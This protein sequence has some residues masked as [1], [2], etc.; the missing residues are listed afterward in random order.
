MREDAAIETQATELLRTLIR[1]ACVNTGEAASGHEVRSVDA[2]E[3]FFAGSG[4]AC[5]RYTAAPGRTSLITRI[6][7]RDRAA[8]TLLLM[9]H[10]DVVPVNPAGWQRDPFAAELV[11]GIVWGRG[12]IDM[13]NLTATMAVATRR[14]ATTGFR[15]RGTLI[16]LA[17][18]DEEAGGTYGADHLVQR[19]ADAVRCD[20]VITESGGV[21]I[22]A[23]SGPV[24][25]V[26]VAE[27]GLNWRTLVV[28]GT[29]GHG[30]RP[31]RTDNA[32]VTAA[33]VVQ[34]LADYRPR[35]RI[36]DVWRDYVRALELDP[37]L[38]AA[39]TDPDRVWQA[40]AELPDLALAREAHACTHTT[41]SP[42]VAHGGTKVNV[43]PDRV[44]IALDVRSLPGVDADEVDAM[45]R[46]ALGDLA[47]R[48]TIESPPNARQEGTASPADTPLVDVLRTVAAA[49]APGSRVV[50]FMATGGTDARYFRWKGVPSYGF[51]LH[52]ARIPHTEYPLM[53]HGHDERVDTE[54][55]RL[56]ARLW[57]AVCREFLG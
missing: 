47:A 49:L 48:V 17:V 54:S 27:K 42:N 20:Y 45:I 30:S 24:L 37:D 38:T 26:A 50:P 53:F 23:R 1:N 32:L 22:P 36:L 57:E 56:S 10:T 34:R 55:L 51:G 28:H 29:P 18:A 21:P 40:A 44:E 43:I 15:P 9:G 3:A 11:D 6:E 33:R 16:Y 4:L 52:S 19:E 8:P 5:E 35:A 7:G 31:F 39:L 14:L 13:L 2:L 12:A 46:D 41:F 25:R